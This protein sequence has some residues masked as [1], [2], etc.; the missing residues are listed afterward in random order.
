MR[1]WREWFWIFS[2]LANAAY[3]QSTDTAGGAKPESRAGSAALPSMGFAST[4]A[5]DEL[6]DALKRFPAF[7]A[8]DKEKIGSPVTIRVSLEV[9]H[10]STASNVASAIFTLGTL[11]L[12]PAVNNRDLTVTYDVLVNESVLSS[13]SYS[14]KITRVFNMYSTDRTHGLGDDGLAWLTGTT[15]EFATDLARDAKFADLEAEYH[16]YYDAAANPSH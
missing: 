6:F 7:A 2:L 12:L 5:S 16:S 13:Y 3:A 15:N 4:I 8:L 14:K 10:T 11:G 9:A 1:R